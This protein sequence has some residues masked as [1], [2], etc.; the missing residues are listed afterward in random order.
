MVSR[1]WWVLV[2]ATGPLVGVSFRSAVR[3][4]AEASGLG[5]T[6]AG[7]GEAFS[8]LVGVWAP[9]LSAYEIAAVFLLPFVAIRLVG[10]DRQSGALKLELQQSIPPLARIAVKAGVLFVGWLVTTLGGVAALLL[11]RVY[12]GHVYAPELLAVWLGH[13]LNAALTI[14]LAAAAASIAE[15]PSTAAIFTFAGTVGTWVISFVAAVHGGLFE[16]VA[17]Y[18]P[19]AMVSRFQQG[20]VRLDLVLIALV[21]AAAGLGAAGIWMRL[22][23][24]IGRRVLHS[25]V[26]AGGAAAAVVLAGTL[27]R[28]SWDLSENRQNSFSRSDEAVLRRIGTPLR[29]EA[30]LAPQDS[31]RSDLERQTL[32]K[33]RR[34]MPAL[35]VRYVSSTSIGLFE[36]TAAHYGEVW[37]ELG[38]RRAMNRLTTREGVLETIFELAGLRVPEAGDPAPYP[39]YPL[40]VEPKGSALLFYGIWPAAAGAGALLA[41]G[42]ARG[43]WRS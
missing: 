36:Q 18:T 25:A 33:L 42:R 34:V 11:W 5:G 6:S 7:V 2:A 22:G 39:G 27:V 19:A 1:S 3:T 14:A 29:I 31:R 32:S 8:P 26:V 17:A 9:T 21:L 12:G 15:H 4:Y 23:D 41:L 30:H 24:P 10:G 28:T 38:G 16:R 37:Y 20:L 13:A 40:A 35:D 43:G